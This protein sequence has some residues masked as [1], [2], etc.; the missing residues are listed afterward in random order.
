M[1]EALGILRE[2]EGHPAVEI[3]RPDVLDLKLGVVKP[4]PQLVEV[5]TIVGLRSYYEETGS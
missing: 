1:K 2:R 5:A 3:A 4:C